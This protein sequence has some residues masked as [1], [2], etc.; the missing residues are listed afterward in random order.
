MD[1]PK[2]CTSITESGRCGEVL[3]LAKNKSGRDVLM[4]QSKQLHVKCSI[5][6]V[7]V[8]FNKKGFIVCP[9]CNAALGGFKK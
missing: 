7:A 2:V 3:Q 8:F 4:C 1:S 5:H 6:K 9:K